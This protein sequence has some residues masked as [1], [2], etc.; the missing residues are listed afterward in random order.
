MWS[1][2]LTA[3]AAHG[4][5]AKDLKQL[6]RDW[7]RTG[8]HCMPTEPYKPIGL[9]CAAIGWHERNSL[10]DRP[11]AMEQERLR[12]HQEERRQFRAEM[13]AARVARREAQSRLGKPAHRAAQQVAAE[14]GARAARKREAAEE[15]ERQARAELVARV[16]GQR[17]GPWF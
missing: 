10:D 11:A 14:I 9:V 8:G 12:R 15:T 6:L 7:E 2:S 3:V 1:R 5:T 17:W 16:P 4:W 13:E